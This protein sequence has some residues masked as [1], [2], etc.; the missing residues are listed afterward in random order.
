MSHR[1]YWVSEVDVDIS[2][3]DTLHSSQSPI[4]RVWGKQLGTVKQSTRRRCWR[5]S[6]RR[7][8]PHTAHVPSFSGGRPA[9]I[10]A[11][12]EYE[13]I[14]PP[15]ASLLFSVALATAIDS[16]VTELHPSKRV[17][18]C[19]IQAPVVCLHRRRSGG[20]DNSSQ[21]EMHQHDVAHYEQ[22]INHL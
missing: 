15:T 21:Y 13:N 11:K 17:D 4:L 6:T 3:V 2:S 10:W 20:S 8:N 22:N 19:L 1:G 16:Q 14:G 5:R 9:R 12:Q 7:F 18:E